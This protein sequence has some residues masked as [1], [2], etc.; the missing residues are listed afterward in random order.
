MEFFKNT[1]INKHAI[2][3]KNS[4]QALY[5][6]TYSLGLVEL[7][8]LKTYIKT[9][10]K[11]GFIWQFKSLAGVSIIFDKKP[12][13]NLRLFVNYSNLNNLTIKNQYSL[14]PI[15]KFF[16]QLGQEK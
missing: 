12:N 6:L 15:G 5:G 10:L 3:F 8:I 7:E 11:T 1:K 16:D 14:S 9:Y 13:G 4:K 2:K